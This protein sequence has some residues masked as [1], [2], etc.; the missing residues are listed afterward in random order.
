MNFEIGGVLIAPLTA[1]IVQAIKALGLSSKW[2]PLANAIVTVILFGVLQAVT[3]GYLDLTTVESVLQMAVL[4]L[5]AMG[6]YEG[7]REAKKRLTS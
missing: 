5:A 4:F 3:L 7:T 2:A 6:F 1:A